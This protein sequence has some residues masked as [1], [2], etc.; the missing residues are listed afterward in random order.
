MKD[1]SIKVNA[2]REVNIVD[3]K[4]GALLEL[5]IYIPELKLGFEYQVCC[6]LEISFTHPYFYQEKHHYISSDY[7]GIPLDVTRRKDSTKR[8]LVAS[9]GE[10]LI[11]VPCWWDGKQERYCKHFHNYYSYLELCL[12]SPQP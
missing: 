6:S 3:P 5:D 10:T 11:T 7:M 9:K 12:V 8:Q 4:T 2:R 1:K